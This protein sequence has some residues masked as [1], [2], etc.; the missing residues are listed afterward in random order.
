VISKLHK[1]SERVSEREQRRLDDKDARDILRVLQATETSVLAAT[2]VRLL[3]ADVARDITREALLVLRDQFTDPRA[4]GSQMAAREVATLVEE[5][6]EVVPGR[7]IQQVAEL[8]CCS[9]PIGSRYASIA[10]A[11]S[12]TSIG[13]ARGLLT[14]VACVL[15]HRSQRAYWRLLR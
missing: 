13:R 15:P 14:P 11:S 1:I 7:E 8:V 5:P 12:A 2:V 3:E 10:S 4:A 6:V 9:N